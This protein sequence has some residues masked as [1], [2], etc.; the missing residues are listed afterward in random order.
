MGTFKGTLALMLALL[1]NVIC[2]TEDFTKVTEDFRTDTEDFTTDADA[3]TENQPDGKYRVNF[4]DNLRGKY[5]YLNTM[6]RLHFLLVPPINLYLCSVSAF[7][8]ININ[9]TDKIAF[10]S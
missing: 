1:I 10:S 9:H 6:S 7:R 2:S 8:Y 5:I 4:K 3:K